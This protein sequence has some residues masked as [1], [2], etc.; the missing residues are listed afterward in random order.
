LAAEL[1]ETFESGIKHLGLI[2]SKGGAFEVKVN[3][4]LIYSK[5]QNGR[6]P[7]MGEV[8]MLVRKFIEEG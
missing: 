6:H 5:L 3:D 7:E 1:L 8:K 4:I 2:P